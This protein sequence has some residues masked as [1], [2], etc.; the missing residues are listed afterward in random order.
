VAKENHTL[1]I[2]CAITGVVAMSIMDVV[3]K[4]LSPDYPLHEIILVRT[5]VALCL[6]LIIVHF[7][8]GF[9][10]LKTKRPMLHLIR[11]LMIVTANITFYLALAVMP[12]AEAAAL[13]YVAPLIIAGLSVP[14]LGET[15]G[16]RRWAAI[17]IGFMGVVLMSGLG[18]DSFKIAA[19]LPVFAALA[20]ALTQLMTR[21]LGVT[22]KASTL[23]FYIGIVFLVVSV[24][25]GLTVG[26]GR[27]VEAGGPGL[28][29][30]LRPWR[31][32]DA[33][34]LALMVVCGFLVA[35]VAYMLSQA[36]RITQ[37]N[38]IAPFE[39]VALPL[40]IL[41]GYLFWNELPDFKA[42]IGIV[43]IGGSGLYVFIHERS[44]QKRVASNA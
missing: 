44:V 37:A 31:M 12:I 41:W 24:G 15:V 42:M 35:V 20:Y 8:G 34:A 38:V 25:F 27:F 5:V 10:L 4:W 11:G 7:E 33:N 36:Y 6:T 16:S 39:Y 14:V 40:A 21:K 19:L 30:L 23:S 29:F 22:D 18:T 1:G 43:L 2:T 28:E 32:P 3:I 9:V 26:D 17:F 13:F